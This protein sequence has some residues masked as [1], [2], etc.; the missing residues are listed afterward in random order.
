MRYLEQQKSNI[1]RFKIKTPEEK[2]SSR[3][4][5]LKDLILHE[6]RLAMSCPLVTH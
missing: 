5:G 4:F 2:R 3:R 6:E 1:C